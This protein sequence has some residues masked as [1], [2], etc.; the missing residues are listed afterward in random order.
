[1]IVPHTFGEPASRSADFNWPNA[2]LR[3]PAG[4]LPGRAPSY[5]A[6]R[7][8]DDEKRGKTQVDEKGH[9]AQDA[10]A[11][12]NIYGFVSFSDHGSTHNSW[13]A[14]WAPTE[15]RVGLFDGMYGRR[16][17][18]A[19][20]EIILKVTADGHMVGEEFTAPAGSAPAIE[21]AISAPDTI[22]RVDVVK[23]GKYVY[24]TRPNARTASIT[25][26]DNDAKAGKSYYYIRIFQR[27][28]EKPDGF[29]EVG[30][31]SPWY[32]TYQ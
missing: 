19:S 3:L 25:F 7:L 32:V 26:R 16:T 14:V 4:D 6:W 31:T 23:D 5:E 18:A 11:A 27:D 17:Y 10:L 2:P 21:A 28:T 9:F 29:P 15:D 22:L 12:G 1:M 20:D 13:A 8:P 30:W 24:T